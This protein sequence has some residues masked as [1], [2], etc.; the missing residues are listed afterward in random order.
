MTATITSIAKESIEDFIKRHP[1]G[2]FTNDVAGR[3]GMNV[4]DARAILKRME[5]SGI[6]YSERET[7]GGS[8]AFLGAGLVWR[9]H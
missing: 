7:A 2:V 6:I 9:R 1:A 3:F 8:G 4:D 5:S